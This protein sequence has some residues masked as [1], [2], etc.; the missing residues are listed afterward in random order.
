MTPRGQPAPRAPLKAGGEEEQSY[1]DLMQ[2]GCFGGAGAA[3]SDY[4][5]YGARK[6]GRQD[7]MHP[8]GGYPQHSRMERCNPN[9]QHPGFRKVT[10][11]NRLGAWW[12]A[13]G[14]VDEVSKKET[15]HVLE[16][17]RH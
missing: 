7:F 2:D 17:P 14:D 10:A 15:N 16:R 12:I 6:Q 5:D 11:G 9:P 13:A 8:G 1:P 3:L 4:N